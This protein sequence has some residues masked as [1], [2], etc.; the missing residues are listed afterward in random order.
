MNFPTIEPMPLHPNA[1]QMIRKVEELSGKLVQV[2][3]D[4]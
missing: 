2:T 1:Q 3:E 4:P